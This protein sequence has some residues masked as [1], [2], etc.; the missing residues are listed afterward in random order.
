MLKAII[1]C[2]G[3]SNATVGRVLVSK[4]TVKAI[5]ATDVSDVRPSSE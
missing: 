4:L 5:M 3:V 2:V 1:D